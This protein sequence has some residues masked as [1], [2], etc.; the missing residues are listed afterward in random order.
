MNT[1]N[2]GEDMRSNHSDSD[3]IV[4]GMRPLLAAIRHNLK[5]SSVGNI[6]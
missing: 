4:Y 6:T 2:L 1:E 5:L 3:H